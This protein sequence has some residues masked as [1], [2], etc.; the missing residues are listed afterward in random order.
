MDRRSVRLHPTPC[1]VYYFFELFVDANS[2]PRLRCHPRLVAEKP[3]IS[4]D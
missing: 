3:L 4:L 2:V 1:E